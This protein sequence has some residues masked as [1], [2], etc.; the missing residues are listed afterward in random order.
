M[1]VHF[2]VPESTSISN[3]CTPPPSV[4]LGAGASEEHPEA[5]ANKAMVS[6]KKH[7]FKTLIPTLKTLNN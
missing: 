6:N 2:Y 3:C 4:L 7:F 5:I 1:K